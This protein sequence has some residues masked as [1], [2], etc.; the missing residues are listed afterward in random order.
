MSVN[1]AISHAGRPV[2]ALRA[3]GLVAALVVVTDLLGGLVTRAAAPA[4]AA[5]QTSGRPGL[6]ALPADR[7]VTAV[8]GLALGCCW[9]WL[10]VT[11]LPFTART[12][13]AL[14]RSDGATGAVRVPAGRSGHAPR[15]VRLCVLLALGGQ[16]LL[17]AAPAGATPH[18]WPD[19][20]PAD[21]LV[22]TA[23]GAPLTGSRPGGS[24]P[25]TVA[26]LPLPER[27]D[28]PLGP[29]PTVPLPA[30]RTAPA[31]P[32]GTPD[33]TVLVRPGDSLWRIAATRVAPPDADAATVARAVVRLRAANS[34]RLGADPD[35]IFPGT[36]LVLPTAAP[37][38]E[39]ER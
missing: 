22:A 35:L 18:P 14:L 2:V 26:G 34:A 21:A 24:G 12:T 17:V 19:H 29:T 13:L 8:A 38:R 10:M 3:L 27:T 30:A 1:R 33:A 16:G 5:W 7:A 37:D 25:A 6:T 39:D 36:H 20:P 32:T 28:E 31:P 11:A 15:L 23:T 9:L 4:L